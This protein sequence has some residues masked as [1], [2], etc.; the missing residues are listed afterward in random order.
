MKNKRLRKDFVESPEQTPEPAVEASDSE[1]QN[2]SVLP[3]LDAR[4]KS[5]TEQ[6]NS[7]I[8]H[9]RKKKPV[10]VPTEQA[11]V[12]FMLSDILDVLEDIK[13]ELRRR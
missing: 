12:V 3:N 9:P 1:A 13:S 4:E 2:A 8:D 7:R 11:A 10:W 6:V 5:V